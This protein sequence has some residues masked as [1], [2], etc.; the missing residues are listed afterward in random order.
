MTAPPPRLREMIRLRAELLLEAG[1]F[2]CPCVDTD[3]VRLSFGIDTG[4]GNSV[5]GGDGRD[6][7]GN[8]AT[9]EKKDNEKAVEIGMQ[10]S[11][12]KED[13]DEEKEGE[14]EDDEK[15]VEMAE[16]KGEEEE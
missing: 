6:G 10:Q 5:D 4:D 7:G 14:E 1:D 13:Q 11:E 15:E 8:G 16:E 9:D 3:V 12:E 2:C